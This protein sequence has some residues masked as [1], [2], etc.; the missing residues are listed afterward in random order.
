MD[1][2]H[3]LPLCLV[4]YTITELYQNSFYL[5]YFRNTENNI[6][7]T[8]ISLLQIQFV[9]QVQCSGVTHVVYH[10]VEVDHIVVYHDCNFITKWT[11]GISKQGYI[12][13]RKC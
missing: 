10:Q 3:L 5:F 4:N 8:H 6:L 13:F 7:K 9:D 1:N 2:Q 12:F 11:S